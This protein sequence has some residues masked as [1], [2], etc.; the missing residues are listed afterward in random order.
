M[1]IFCKASQRDWQTDTKWL[2]TQMCL[3]DFEITNVEKKRSHKSAEKATVSV[4]FYFYFIFYAISID[5]TLDVSLPGVPF[6]CHNPTWRW[7]PR[8]RARWRMWRNQPEW[9]SCLL[10]LSTGKKPTNTPVT[11]LWGWGERQKNNNNLN[12]K[13]VGKCAWGEAV[14]VQCVRWMWKPLFTVTMWW[15]STWWVMCD[16]RMRTLCEVNEHGA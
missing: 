2:R 5:S 11:K 8:G 16:V 4:C 9:S 15:T 13:Y 10:S 6:K 7:P 14:K 12:V 3:R 1:S